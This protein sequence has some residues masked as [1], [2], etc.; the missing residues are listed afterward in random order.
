[1]AGPLAGISAAQ[2]AQQKL[3]EQ[4]AQGNKAGASKF[5]QA[6]K[7][8]GAQGTDG[9]NGI[10]GVNRAEHAQKAQAIQQTHQVQQTKQVSQVAKL[11]KAAVAKVDDNIKIDQKMTGKGMDP[12]S[13][14]SEVNKGSSVL[15]GTVA[16]IE[17]GGVSI[18]KLINGGFQ[19][20]TFSNSE[21]LSLQAGMYKYTQEL[22]L[23]SKVVEKATSGLKDTLKTQV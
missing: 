13:Q 18:D 7:P 10:N 2:I 11:D 1:M 8:P 3:P 21:L 5:D 12:V 15:M 22:D 4:A 20:K 16:E 17:K 14:K 23:C 6:M 19:G 9:A